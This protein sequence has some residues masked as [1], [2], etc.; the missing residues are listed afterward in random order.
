MRGGFSESSLRTTLS[1]LVGRH[2]SAVVDTGTGQH[3]LSALTVGDLE[4]GGNR[5][6]SREEEDQNRKNE[7]WSEHR[8]NPP[9]TE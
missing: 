3:D 5:A 8:N 6:G 9:F 1:L 7:R 4:I 2:E